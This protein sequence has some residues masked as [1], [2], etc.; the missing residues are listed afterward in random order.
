[1][2]VQ[3]G[4]CALGGDGG[5]GGKEGK[6]A[7]CDAKEKKGGTFSL[8]LFVCLFSLGIS[9]ASA[10]ISQLFISCQ[11]YNFCFVL[12]VIIVVFKQRCN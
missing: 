6:S 10:C 12:V 9:L 4:K 1:M 2:G 11:T 5:K 7:V 8:F 3:E